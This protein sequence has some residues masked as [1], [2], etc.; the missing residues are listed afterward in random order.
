MTDDQ[1][2]EELHNIN[3]RKMDEY[4]KYNGKLNSYARKKLVE[5]IIKLET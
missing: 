1:L 2:R 5:D 3:R 4:L